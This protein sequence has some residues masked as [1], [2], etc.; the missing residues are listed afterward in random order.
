MIM[1]LDML[2]GLNTRFLIVIEIACSI[3]IPTQAAIVNLLQQVRQRSMS[4][5]PP[6]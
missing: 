3:M 2:L 1:N 4:G 6:R 5:Q